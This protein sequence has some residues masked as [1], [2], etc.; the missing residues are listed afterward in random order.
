MSNSFNLFKGIRQGDPLSG[1]LFALCI[2]PL[3]EGIRQ[4]STIC[5][6]SIAGES[7]KLSLY[8]DEII[9]YLVIP[10]SCIILLMNIIQEFGKTSGSKLNMYKSGTMIFGCAIKEETKRKYSFHWDS[11]MIEYLGVNITKDLDN[12]YK[13][14]FRELINVIKQDFNGW[15]LIPF[16]LWEKVNIIQMNVLPR[17]LFLFT[18]LPIHIPPSTF[19]EW[20]SLITTFLWNCMQVRLVLNYLKLSKE[21]GGTGL[22]HLK[23]YY[24]AAHTRNIE[25]TTG[26]FKTKWRNMEE[27]GEHATLSILPFIKHK[28]IIREKVENRWVKETKVWKEI[29]NEHKIGQDLI[30]M[31]KIHIDPEFTPNKTDQISQFINGLTKVCLYLDNCL[32]R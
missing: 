28:K 15:A 5:G 4:E 10:E 2:E 30:F 27:M 24:Q 3:A 1:L 17:F 31:R 22:S 6:L 20:N 26:K 25:W 9:V 23:N 7:H 13:K 21:V 11:E 18:A 12:P 29:C 19:K 14:N 32:E 16:S 8:A